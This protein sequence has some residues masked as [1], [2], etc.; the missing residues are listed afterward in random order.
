MIESRFRS[1]KVVVCV[2]ALVAIAGCSNAPAAVSGPTATAGPVATTG[3]GA[4]TP[5]VATAAPTAAP[6]RT[7][8]PTKA[9]P[10]VDLVL[11]GKYAVVAKGTAGTCTL[12]KDLAGMVLS[13]G[14]G[15][16]EADYP[17]LKDGLYVS[18]GNNGYV[19]IKWLVNATTGFI[20][21]ADQKGVSADHHSI[22]IDVDL[23]PTEHIKGT[24]ACP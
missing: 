5:P 17:G 21:S 18:E 15:A 22:T 19:T 23:G 20:N 8:T 7:I 2:I 16:V 9:L 1:Q 3:S 14:F 13:F 6:V 12:G 24:I 10:T 4:T 11:S